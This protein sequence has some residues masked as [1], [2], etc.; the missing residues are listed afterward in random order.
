MNRILIITYLYI[1]VISLY[2]LENK[3][4]YKKKVSCG[5]T[6]RPG[7]DGARRAGEAVV[8]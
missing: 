1:K 4:F 5:I 7:M 6:R 8:T 3:G 2:M